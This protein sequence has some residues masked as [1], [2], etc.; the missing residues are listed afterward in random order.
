RSRMD[1]LGHKGDLTLSVNAFIPKP[2]TPYQWSPVEDSRVLKRRFKLL[3][4]GFKKDRRIRVL[5]ESLKETMLQAALARGNRRIGE[6]LL[7][8]CDQQ[9]GLK[10]AFQH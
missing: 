6:L 10:E 4:N 3:Q 8:A 9:T 2:F 5:T 1:E 7:W